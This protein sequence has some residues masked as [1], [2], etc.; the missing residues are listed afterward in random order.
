MRFIIALAFERSGLGVTS[1]ISDTAGDL[2]V[3]MAKS[4]T[5]SA[6]TNITRF[7]LFAAR[8]SRSIAAT[9]ITVPTNMKGVLLPRLWFTLSDHAPNIGSMMRAKMLSMAIIPPER[10]SPILKKYFSI[11]GIILSYICQKALIARNAK[12]MVIV[13]LLSSFM[14][15]F[16]SENFVR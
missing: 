11:S 15:L 5:K 9:A 1:G 2:K 6:V 16:T 12:P 3:L 7:L 8:G 13:R 10:V 14:I 4:V